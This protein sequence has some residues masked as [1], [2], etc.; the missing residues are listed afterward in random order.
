LHNDIALIELAEDLE[1]SNPNIGVACLPYKLGGRQEVEGPVVASGWGLTSLNGQG[2]DL[3]K[4]VT[5]DMVGPTKCRE[6]HKNHGTERG[7]PEKILN[8]Q[9]CTLGV[10]NVDVCQGDSGGSIDGF[11]GGKWYAF[12][13]VSYGHGCAEARHASLYTRV[14]EYTSWIETNTE[15][16]FCNA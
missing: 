15:T 8:T 5:L 13:I 2:S 11:V 1:L 16:T 3:L 6:L 7:T 12:G 14:S 4:K 9:V 10:N